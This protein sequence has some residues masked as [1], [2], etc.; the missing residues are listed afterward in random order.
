MEDEKSKDSLILPNIPPISPNIA[1]RNM[2][3]FLSSMHM[4]C[5]WANFCNKPK[6]KQV[7]DK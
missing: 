3:I 5:I 1:T 7:V 6:E 4:Y 2:D